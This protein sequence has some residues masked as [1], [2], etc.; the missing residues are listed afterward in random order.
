MNYKCKHCVNSYPETHDG[1]TILKCKKN[2]R[3][4][5]PPEFVEFWG[6]DDFEDIQLSLFPEER[7]TKDDNS[8]NQ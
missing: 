3:C 4:C 6:C 5:P 2:G 7:R 1:V 8:H